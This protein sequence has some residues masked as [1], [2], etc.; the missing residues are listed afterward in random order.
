MAR[1]MPGSRVAAAQPPPAGSVEIGRVVVPPDDASRPAAP[2]L[3]DDV[4]FRVLQPSSERVAWTFWSSV[5][6]C[7]FPDVDRIVPQPAV[8]PPPTRLALDRTDAV[9]LSES[10]AGLPG[11]SDDPVMVQLSES[12]EVTAGEGAA[13]AS[14]PL[15]RSRTL[16]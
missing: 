5:E 4:C 6:A 13:A 7:R 3:S 10:L 9:R 15:P 11:G 14:I 12:V 2:P 16:G 8:C 1:P